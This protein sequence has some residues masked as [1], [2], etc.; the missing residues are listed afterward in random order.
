MI[1]KWKLYNSAIPRCMDGRVGL[2]FS[3]T[4]YYI[5][6]I[7]SSTKII[8]SEGIRIPSV[9]LHLVL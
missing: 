1:K 2:G 8:E 6:F 9:N 7:T 4:V 3:P 5:Q